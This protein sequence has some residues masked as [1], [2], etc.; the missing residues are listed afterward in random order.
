MTWSSLFALCR[1]GLSRADFELD[2]SAFISPWQMMQAIRKLRRG[3][4]CGPND[5]PPDLIKAG[6]PMFAMQMAC[7]TN[8]VIA[9]AHEPT[10]WRGGKLIPLYKGKGCPHDPAS[11]RSI[12]ISD[13]TAKLYHA[14]LRRPLEQVWHESMHSMQFGG[15]AGCGVDLPHHFLQMHQCW[16]RHF[17]KP[18]AIVF[19]DMKAAFYSVLRQALTSCT[20]ANNAFQFAMS[21]LGLSE[22]EVGDILQA[23]ANENAVA[24]ASSHVERLVHDTMTGTFFTVEGIDTP[25]ATQKGTRPG[26]PIGDLLFNLTMSRIL[27]EMKDLVLDSQTAEW[28]GDPARCRDF[29]VPEALPARGFADVSFVDDCAVAIHADNL[30]QLQDIAQQVV[31]AMHVAARRR[32]LHLNFDAGKT[33]MLWHCRVE[34]T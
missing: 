8:K 11:F 6:G 16:A 22:K 1:P 29:S 14:C 20:D 9:H 30:H 23:V 15:R 26:D 18:A 3:K 7:L 13:F 19:F 17:K 34:G 2:P 32:G 33:E 27:A 21:Q 31:S 28:F 24:G 5:M 25:V 10:S 12:F 4:A